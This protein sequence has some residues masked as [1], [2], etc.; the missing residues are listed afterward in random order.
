MQETKQDDSTR[1]VAKLLYDL[2]ESAKKAR[3]PFIETRDSI[4][5]YAYDKDFQFIYQDADQELFFKAKIAKAAEFLEIM[6]SALYP[7][8]PKVLVES[9]PYATPE[10]VKR[11]KV[12]EQYGDYAF[13]H[14]DLQ[15]HGTRMVYEALLG[16]R[17]VLWT[18]YNG[19][20]GCVQSVF[21]TVDNLFLD[22]DAKNREELNWVGRRRVKPRW[23]LANSHPDKKG[24]IARIEKYSDK[25][26][27]VR[28]AE[29]ASELVEYFEVYSLVPLQNYAPSFGKDPQLIPSLGEGPLKYTFTKDLLIAAEPWEINWFDD[30]AWPCDWYDPLERPGELWPAA[31]L[32]SSLGHIR[33]LNWIYTLYLSKMRV[34]TR[35]P[36]V[37]MTQSGQ[38]LKDDQ[39]IKI[40]KGKD[41]EVVKVSVNG[42]TLKLSDLVQQFKFDTGVEEFERFAKI[43]GEA[44]EKSSGLYDVLYTGA[45]PTQIRNAATADMIKNSSQSRVA[46]MQARMEQFMGRIARKTIFAARFIEKPE[47]IAKL[48]GPDA[49]NYWGTLAPPEMVQQEAQM[50]QQTGQMMTQQFTAQLSQPIQTPGG[51][52]PPPPVNPQVIEE[53]VKTALGPPQLISME[54]WMSEAGRTIVGGSMRPLSP[55]QQIDN[56]NIALNQLA[57]AIA[58]APGGIGLVAAIAREFAKVNQYSRELQDAAAKFAKQAE[59]VCDMQVN[60]ALNPMP[61]APPGNAS[62]SGTPDKGPKA[63]PSGG[64]PTI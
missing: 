61:P 28:R 6:G 7:T 13:K 32:S 49:A 44:F 41:M 12:E 1:K 43:V 33:A 38:G 27:E 24:D 55:G 8:N 25:P 45:T 14:G 20:K 53:E 48:F 37:V 19:R 23:V 60:A 64:T 15:T 31:P 56:L 54:A 26:S 36:L 16:G 21:D 50:R 18:G 51:V 58:Q 22:P 17:G 39:I 46:N 34:T 9:A 42:N 29:P 10:Q 5:Q 47:N 4:K 30:D 3:E 40:L 63:G 57:P 59:S 52:M 2:I 11:H 35:T 62:G